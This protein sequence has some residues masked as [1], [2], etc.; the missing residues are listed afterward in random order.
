MPDSVTID[1]FINNDICIERNRHKGDSTRRL[2]VF[3]A[4]FEMRDITA[5]C[6]TVEQELIMSAV[7]RKKKSIR[8]RCDPDERK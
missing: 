8:K 6:S 2:S 1:Y 3:L 7:K 5:D 4:V